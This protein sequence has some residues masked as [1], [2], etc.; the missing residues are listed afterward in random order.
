MKLKIVNGHLIAGSK[1][2]YGDCKACDAVG[3]LKQGLCSKCQHTTK[4]EK[5]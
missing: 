1:P 3:K 5:R 4:E 2:G